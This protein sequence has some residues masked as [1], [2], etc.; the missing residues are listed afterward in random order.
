MTTRLYYLDVEQLDTSQCMYRVEDG[1][2][3]ASVSGREMTTEE[4]EWEI[5]V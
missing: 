2:T 5:G 4:K 1:N 3:Y